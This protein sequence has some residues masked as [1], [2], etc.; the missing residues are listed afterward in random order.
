[1]SRPQAVQPEGRSSQGT[2]SAPPPAAGAVAIPMHLS[3]LKAH[4]VT[5][6]VEMAVANGIDGGG[7]KAA[8]NGS[9]QC[10]LLT[11]SAP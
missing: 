7:N 11:C 5:Q 8:G 2:E 3:E 9:N 10:F 1:M 4:H 6:L